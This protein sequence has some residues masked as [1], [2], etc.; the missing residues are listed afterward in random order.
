MS[1]IISGAPSPDTECRQSVASADV[2]R[3]NT[4]SYKM[5]PRLWADILAVLCGGYGM[6]HVATVT[7]GQIVA[8]RYTGTETGYR[9]WLLADNGGECRVQPINRETPDIPDV[10]LTNWGYGLD[11]GTLAYRIAMTIRGEPVDYTL[12]FPELPEE[13]RNVA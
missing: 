1:K 7:G 12:S 2:I 11:A 3:F 5:D 9:W 4:G 10:P 13:C 8:E 6:R